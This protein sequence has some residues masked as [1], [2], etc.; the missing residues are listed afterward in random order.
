[1]AETFFM[2]QMNWFGLLEITTIFCRL[3]ALVIVAKIKRLD[4]AASF[5]HNDDIVRAGLA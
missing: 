4:I 2:S 3:L 5:Q 1:M